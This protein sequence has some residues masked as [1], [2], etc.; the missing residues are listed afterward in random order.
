MTARWFRRLVGA[1][2]GIGLLAFL[3]ASWPAYGNPA[4]QMTQPKSQSPTGRPEYLTREVRQSE[5]FEEEA[6][7][8][9]EAMNEEYR[10][11]GCYGGRIVRYPKLSD[12]SVVVFLAL[13][14]QWQ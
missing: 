4:P 2:I 14:T 1:V 10:R 7:A 13:C 5:R 3:L 6:R 8:A 9:I 11:Y 12:P